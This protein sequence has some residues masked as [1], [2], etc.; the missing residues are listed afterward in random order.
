[1][2]AGRILEDALDPAPRRPTVAMRRAATLVLV[3]L[4]Y[5]AV[6]IGGHS[7]AALAD[8]MLSRHGLAPEGPAMTGMLALALVAYVVATA[9]PF[10]P[11][12][13]IGLTLIMLLGAR[14]VPI[15]YL[16]T[17][18]ALVLAFLVGRHI[19]DHRLARL[20]SGLGL[21][22]AAALVAGMSGL[23]TDGRI[24]HL[25]AIAPSG[26][27]TWVLQYRLVSLALLV[28][29][30]GNTLLGGGGGL[31]IL[32]GMSRTMSLPAFTLCVLVAVSPIPLAVLLFGPA[33]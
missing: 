15:V 20:F 10:V 4:A 7:V 8:G 18:A 1:M 19:P 24:R 30:P 2:M 23:D 14:I 17:V 32:A 33:T 28:N 16:A 27:L 21:H 11:G 26:W 12:A 13:E 9:L 25:A 6:V 31:A 22:R 3:G 5:A 29:L